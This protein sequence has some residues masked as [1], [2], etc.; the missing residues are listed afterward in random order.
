MSQVKLPVAKPFYGPEWSAF[1]E[2]F[3]KNALF[4][5]MMSAL[6][7]RTLNLIRIKNGFTD[8]GKPKY[9]S[10]FT[11]FYEHVCKKIFSDPMDASLLYAICFIVM[12]WF[13]AWLLHRKKIY[14]RV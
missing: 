1:F 13:F 4:I 11:W 14:I 7:P 10:P 5:F 9:L 8:E 2:V 6:I 12:M 3:G